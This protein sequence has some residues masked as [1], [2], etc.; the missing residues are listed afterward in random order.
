M[1]LL[2]SLFTALIFSV[3]VFA[4][5]K[6][7]I[8]GNVYDRM[9]TKDLPHVNV[10]VLNPD[11]TV[12]VETEAFD[13]QYKFNEVNH[14]YARFDA[15]YYKFDIPVAP[16][17]YIMKFAKE[18]Y[19]TYFQPLDLSKMG[20]RQFEL[21]LPPVYLTPVQEGPTVELDEVVVKTSKIKFYHK[22]DTI[23]YNA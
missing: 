7:T 10:A 1:R 15:G 3:Y 16:A 20:N 22:G 18:G 19:D 13:E 4:E 12:V 5:Q 21:K 9:T 6:I 14:T 8:T 17:P 23:V 2:F 11:S